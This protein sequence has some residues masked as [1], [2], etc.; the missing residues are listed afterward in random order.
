MNEEMEYTRLIDDSL[1][2][3]I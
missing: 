3:K 2:Q 1:M